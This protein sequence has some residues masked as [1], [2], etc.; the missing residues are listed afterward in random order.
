[1]PMLLNAF[2]GAVEIPFLGCFIGKRGLRA[3]PS[4]LKSIVDWPVPKN[5]KKLRKWLGLASYLH[6]HSENYADMAWPLS[7]LLK[8]DIAWC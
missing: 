6:K 7:R 5:Q 1:M 8:K 3:D 2:F 4:K